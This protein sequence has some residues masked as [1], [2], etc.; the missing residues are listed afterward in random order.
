MESCSRRDAR[1][2]G[3]NDALA[4]IPAIQISRTGV[5][6]RASTSRDVFPDSP[7]RAQSF[8]KNEAICESFVQNIKCDILLSAVLSIL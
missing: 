3:T 4:P 1:S 5:A 6:N 2:C 8:G 7:L